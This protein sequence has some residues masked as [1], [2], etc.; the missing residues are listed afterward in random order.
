[1][2]LELRRLG[3]KEV[4]PLVGG[5][6]AWKKSGYPMAMSGEPVQQSA[7]SIS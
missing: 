1:V 2:A 7:V 3:I 6:H 5:W 4:R